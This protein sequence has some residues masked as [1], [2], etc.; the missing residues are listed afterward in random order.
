MYEQPRGNFLG[1]LDTPSGMCTQGR[2]VKTLLF[3]S[4]AACAPALPT[5]LEITPPTPPFKKHQENFKKRKKKKRCFLQAG[6]GGH[7][8]RGT[9]CELSGLRATAGVLTPRVKL[10]KPS[11]RKCI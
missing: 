4:F 2:P 11:Y 6:S 5:F 9:T 10:H 8:V 1:G 7:G 3:L